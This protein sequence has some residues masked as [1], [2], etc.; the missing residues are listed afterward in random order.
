MVPHMLAKE[1][2]HLREQLKYPEAQLDRS[3]GRRGVEAAGTK[4]RGGAPVP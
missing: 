2:G 1:K 3:G 4:V